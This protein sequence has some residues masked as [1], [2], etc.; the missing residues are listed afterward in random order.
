MQHLVLLLY[1]LYFGIVG[2]LAPAVAA[3]K[4]FRMF[5]SPRGTSKVPS[6]LEGMLAEA[7]RIELRVQ[8][9]R[10]QAYR[11]TAPEETRGRVLL[12]HGWESRAGRIANWVEPLRARGYEVL[13]FD[14]PAHGESDGG[15]VT[16]VDFAAVI[17]DLHSRFGP[18]SAF[19]AHSFGVIASSAA[20]ATDPSITPQ[21]LIFVAGP[22]RVA[23]EIRRFAKV[24]GI[25]EGVLPHFHRAMEETSHR[26]V[27]DWAISSLLA[28]TDVPILL[29]HDRDDLEIP[30]AE[31]EAV[32]AALPT[33]RLISTEGFGHH[34]ILREASVVKIGLSFLEEA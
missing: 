21:K 5:R 31:A 20:M 26:A 7:E 2:R 25:P 27:R 28:A 1:K 17:A 16:P 18:F 12:V 32:A 9:R 6:A 22:D 34:R 14:G 23:D 10:I 8:D 19:V 33:A 3:R 24:L 15:L 30:H 29:L 13:A 4:A 11:W